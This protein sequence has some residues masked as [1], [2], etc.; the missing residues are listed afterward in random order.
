MSALR[1]GALSL[2]LTATSFAGEGLGEFTLADMLADLGTEKGKMSQVHKQLSQLARRG[3]AVEA[4]LPGPVRQRKER[5]AGQASLRTVLRFN[6]TSKSM[7]LSSQA[8][9]IDADLTAK[10]KFFHWPHT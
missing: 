9:V 5:Q 10:D 1:P 7:G 6:F 4:P 3:R 2:T 8:F